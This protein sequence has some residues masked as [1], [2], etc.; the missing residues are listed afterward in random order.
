M[1]YVVTVH[2]QTYEVDL[3]PDGTMVD[4]VPVTADFEHV[5]GTSLRSL[6]VDGRSFR[7]LGQRDASGTWSLHVGG[8]RYR[9][10]AVDERTLAIREMTGVAAGPLGPRPVRAPMP[11][12]MVKIEVAVGDTVEAGQ[13]VAIV[14]AMKME[15]ELKAESAGV[16]TRIHVEVGQAVDKD[17]IL[18]DLAAPGQ[19]QGEG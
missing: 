17:Q 10:E 3:G 18:I 11:G 2:G 15:N 6:L 5:E 9:G 12:M 7:I 16:V 19:D 14:E 13:G 8:R 4:G 1:R